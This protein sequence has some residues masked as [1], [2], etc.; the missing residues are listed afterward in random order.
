MVSRILFVL[1]VSSSIISCKNDEDDDF[2]VPCGVPATVK[3]L[4]GLDGCGFVFELED[5]TR[6]EPV[7]IGYCYTPPFPKEQIQ[8]PLIG[9]E[10]VDG[11]KVFIDYSVIQ[12]NSVCMAGPMARI[13]CISDFG[14][15]GP[16]N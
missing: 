2:T 1:L 3:N 8:D 10:F 9:F 12:G 13:N 4:S 5:G 7:R 15:S 14:K 11:K 16:D 6:L